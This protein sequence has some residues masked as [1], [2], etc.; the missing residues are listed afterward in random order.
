MSRFCDVMHDMDRVQGRGQGMSVED[1]DRRGIFSEK[2]GR[3]RT[4][5]SKEDKEGVKL[6]RA[7]SRV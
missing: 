2:R 5:R 6:I 3:R 1:L 4:A 7:S